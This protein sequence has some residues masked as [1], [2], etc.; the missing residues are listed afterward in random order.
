MR[1]HEN[2]VYLMGKGTEFSVLEDHLV[3]PNPPINERSEVRLSVVFLR[4][5][6]NFS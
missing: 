5:S 3:I 2:G 1:G 6:Y 4:E